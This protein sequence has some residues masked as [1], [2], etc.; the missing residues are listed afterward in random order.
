LNTP[1]SRPATSVPLV[2]TRCSIGLAP[3]AVLNQYRE[4]AK[5]YIY[6]LGG[7]TMSNGGS[8]AD[9][10]AFLLEAA[11]VLNETG[12]DYWGAAAAIAES[13]WQ[14]REKAA[15]EVQDA[16]VGDAA[17]LRLAERLSG[18]HERALELLKERIG[19]RVNASTG[20]PPSRKT[21]HKTRTTQKT[22]ISAA[23]PMLS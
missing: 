5:G 11:R 21:R 10:P 2:R 1:P 17:A 8:R 12:T 16:I 18:G 7:L 9:D 15:Q 4:A 3:R 20:P 19:S 14:L 13:A 22:R 23:R 6:L